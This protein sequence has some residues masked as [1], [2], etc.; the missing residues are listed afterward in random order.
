MAVASTSSWRR[1]GG[2]LDLIGKATSSSTGRDCRARQAD[3]MLD[4]GFIHDVK[5]IVARLPKQRQTLL[6]SATMPADIARLAAGILRDPAR[7]EVTPAAST[8]ERAEQ[9]VMLSSAPDKR[10]LLC[11]MLEDGGWP[12]S[13][14]H[15]YQARRNKVAEQLGRAGY[16]ADAI[17]ATSRRAPANARSKASA[18]AMS[19][20]RRHRYRCPRHRHRRHHHVVN[21]S[22]QRTGKPTSTDR[23]PPPAPVPGGG[24]LAVDGE[25][26]RL[27]TRH[28]A[29]DRPQGGGGRRRA[30]GP[31]DQKA[32]GVSQAELLP[33]YRRSLGG[34]QTATLRHDHSSC[35]PTYKRQA[36]KICVTVEKRVIRSRPRGNFAR[37]NIAKGGTAMHTRHGLIAT[38][39]FCCFT[40]LYYKWP[41]G[42]HGARQVPAA[43]P[44]N[45]GGCR[46]AAG[47]GP[48][49]K[50]ADISNT[51]RAK[52]LEGVLRRPGQFVVCRHRQGWISYLQPDGKLVPV[53]NCTR[54]R[55]SDDLRAA[56]HPLEGRKLYL[57]TRHRGILTYDPKTKS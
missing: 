6:F 52:F 38:L 16:R 21:T 15:P 13:G 51:P 3:R 9:R 28:R 10:A 20:S 35:A 48:I 27:S 18:P 41:P 44:I 31:R 32:R 46:A 42:K 12:G 56:G 23:P 45:R 14:L 29:S 40:I 2:L 55:I 34:R 22:C 54:R 5:K 25:E 50:F 53:V 57:T 26:S 43:G 1:R 30:F 4:M 7:V 19:G 47:V 33:A 24:D 17:M 36:A 39:G 8:V 37:P 11:A 49:E